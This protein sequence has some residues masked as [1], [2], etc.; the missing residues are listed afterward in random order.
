[1]IKYGVITDRT[2]ESKNERKINNNI[3][4]IF[5]ITPFMLLIFNIA[6]YDHIIH[7]AAKLEA[8]KTIN[9]FP[10]SIKYMLKIISMLL[11]MLITPPY[12]KYSFNVFSYGVSPL[13]RNMTQR[14]TAENINIYMVWK[15]AN[16]ILSSVL[17]SA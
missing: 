3:A 8:K 9:L 16:L 13:K 7:T 2:F 1:M 5:F 4:E 15:K 6:T 14:I 10:P 12:I 17:P 11:K